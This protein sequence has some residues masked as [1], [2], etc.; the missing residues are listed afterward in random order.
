MNEG[1]YKI[2]KH[3]FYNKIVSL[4]NSNKSAP[5]KL[6]NHGK[7]NSYV[8]TKSSANYVC[9]CTIVHKQTNWGA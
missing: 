1:P 5:T 2:L 4:K 6:V 9:K 3:R 7:G 8:L